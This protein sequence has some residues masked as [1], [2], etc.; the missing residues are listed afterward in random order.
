MLPFPAVTP[1]RTAL[2]LAL[3]LALPHAAAARDAGPADAEPALFNVNARY[4]VESVDFSGS[5]RPPVSPSLARTIGRMIGHKL[6]PEALDRLCRQAG[7]ELH[8][9]QVTFR[10]A[11]GTTP[12]HVRV[13][14]E[15]ERSPSRFDVSFPRMVY[16]SALGWTGEAT[17]TATFGSSTLSF[18]MVSDT[19][20]AVER[21]TGV[22]A[23]FQSPW[24]SSGRVHL[25]LAFDDFENQYGAA[26]VSAASLDPSRPELFRS[27]WDL[28]PTVTI[29]LA[30]PLTLTVGFDMEQLLPF[31]PAAGAASVNALVNT[32][33][34]QR[35]WT[36]A[37]GSRQE[38]DAGYSL[39]AATRFLGSNFAFAKQEFD[40][41]YSWRLGRHLV[42]AS[43]AS[44]LIAGSAPL[45]D[46]FVLGDSTALRGW[47]K[48]ELDPLGGTRLAEASLTYGYRA[49]RLYYDA[50]SLWSAA[51]PA[52]LHSSAPAAL[53][54][55]GPAG[56]PATAP[57]LRQSV[58]AGFEKDR[59]LLAV[60]IPLGMGRPDPVV[61]A[62]MNF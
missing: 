31:S 49:A 48:Y 46:R 37:D 47:D 9:R 36:G 30:D 55:A 60:A 5:S 59:F 14:L 19:D 35:R 43:L 1:F 42:R 17:A 56:S 3:A 32:L 62:G 13:L 52:S 41:A 20:S 61:I 12:D 27:R 4:T 57:E 6:N 45:L 58:G 51:A 22:R 40:A 44:G 26:T 10:L 25:S 11:R 21:F 33:R 15:V 16:N 23:A 39:R 24:P 38:L 18:G 34:Y 53:Y 8:A 50:G 54:S 29:S 2:A 7:G 28:I